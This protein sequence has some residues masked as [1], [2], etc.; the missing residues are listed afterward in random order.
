MADP[1]PPPTIS[2]EERKELN[3]IIYA[4]TEAVWWKFQNFRYLLVGFTAT[5]Q[6]FFFSTYFVM[7]QNYLQ[8]KK[9]VL[10]QG[11][12]HQILIAIPVFS[13]LSLIVSAELGRRLRK[14]YSKCSTRAA[15]IE[16]EK[17]DTIGPFRIMEKV[18]PPNKG[19][20]RSFGVVTLYVIALLAWTYL[21]G[22]A[23]WR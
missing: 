19:W 15:K 9:E 22:I 5:A 23:V 14:I 17:W 16:E 7:H 13:I 1:P 2:E 6:A 3:K 20:Q 18:S 4:S 8:Y 12:Y 11:F 10:I 21:F